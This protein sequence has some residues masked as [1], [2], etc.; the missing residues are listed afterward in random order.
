MEIETIAKLIRVRFT[1]YSC[2]MYVDG[3]LELSFYR[4]SLF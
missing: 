3:D 1:T 4:K 2:S